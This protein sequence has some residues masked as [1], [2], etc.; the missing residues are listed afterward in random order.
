MAPDGTP[1]SLLRGAALLLCAGV[2]AVRAVP[3]GQPVTPCT[4]AGECTDDEGTVWDLGSPFG[5]IQRVGGTYNAGSGPR[6]DTFTYAFRLYANLGV[7]PDI[8]TESGIDAASAMR[9]QAFTVPG[10]D[11]PSC[12]QIGPD[13]TAD[14]AYTV[15]RVPMGVTF[16]YQLTGGDTLEINLRCQVGAGVGQ[17][18]DAFWST[19]GQYTIN[20]PNGIT[21]PG[22]EPKCT[23][24]GA[25]TDD[26]GTVWQLARLGQIQR[27]DGPNT[28]PNIFTYAFRLYNNLNVIPDVCSSVGITSASA[29]RYDTSGENPDCT[30]IGPDMTLDPTYVIR[31]VPTGLLFSY[32]FGGGN[33]LEVNLICRE[34]SKCRRR[35]L[36]AAAALPGGAVAVHPTV[37]D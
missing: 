3:A 9:Y 21:C 25:C 26:E 27:I 23:I 17:P 33:T 35:C 19:P 28:A 29:M 7:V 30:Q 13:M 6:P 18:L 37:S 5:R 2:V 10:G 12:G 1:G 36:R 32:Q 34:V 8:C 31:K 4:P 11:P 20:W 24:G 15:R 14:P 16:N 22:I